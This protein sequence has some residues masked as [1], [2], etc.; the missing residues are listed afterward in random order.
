[1]LASRIGPEWHAPCEE[2][3]HDVTAMPNPCPGRCSLH[4]ALAW[5]A[6]AA[7]LPRRTKGESGVVWERYH[8]LVTGSRSPPHWDERTVPRQLAHDFPSHVAAPQ[9]VAAMHYCSKC[10][11][12][13]DGSR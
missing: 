5:N 3:R 9:A 13:L 11:L 6:D 1:M 12:E 4:R 8:L 7:L 10:H 2:E